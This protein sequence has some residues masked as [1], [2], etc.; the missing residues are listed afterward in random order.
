[1][2]TTKKR[3][4]RQPAKKKTGP[5]PIFAKAIAISMRLDQ[6]D[7]DVFRQRAEAAGKPVTTWMRDAAR[8]EAGVQ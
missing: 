1:M 6:S 5:K 3:K 7:Y 2:T 8:K 4:K